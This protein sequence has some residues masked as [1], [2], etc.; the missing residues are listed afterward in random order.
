MKRTKRFYPTPKYV[1]GKGIV[2]VGERGGQFKL[3]MVDGRYER[4][5]V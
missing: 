3:T 2:Y 4:R 1:P 5:Y